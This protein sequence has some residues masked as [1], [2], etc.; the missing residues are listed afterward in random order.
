MMQC[1]QICLVTVPLQGTLAVDE[2][3]LEYLLALMGTDK[4]LLEARVNSSSSSSRSSQTH[5]NNSSSSSSH[6]TGAAAVAAAGGGGGGTVPFPDGKKLAA[7]VSQVKEVLPG[8][9]NGF[10]TACLYYTGFKA[11]QVRVDWGLT[12]MGCS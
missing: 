10:I 8:Y 9:G 4:Q 12:V 1:K 6:S 5:A 2:A 11:E 7:M 3:P